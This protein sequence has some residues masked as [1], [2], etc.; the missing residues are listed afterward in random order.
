VLVEPGVAAVMAV[1]IGGTYAVIYLVG[2]RWQ[3]RLGEERLAANQARFRA[4]QD[5]LR[6]FKTIKILGLERSAAA[7]FRAPAERMARATAAAGLLAQMPR[8]LMEAVALGGM[9]A[10]HQPGEDLGD[11]VA[12]AL[13]GVVRRHLPAGAGMSSTRLRPH[14]AISQLLDLIGAAP[15]IEETPATAAAS[16]TPVFP[17][18]RTRSA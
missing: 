2:R 17:R 4:A 10:V 9:V 15:D 1:L 6:G 8:Y 18:P 16:T 3:V 7:R 11:A 13:R 12:R 5:T 14:P